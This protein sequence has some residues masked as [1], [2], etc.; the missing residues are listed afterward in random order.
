M[1][2]LERFFRQIVLNLAA[3]DPARLHRPLPLTDIRESIVPYRANRRALQLES[4]EDYELVV[5]RLC[6][7]E[8]GLARTE[9]DEVRAE[10]V[11]EVGGPNPD[12]T[13]VKRHGEALVSL[14]P[15]SLAQALD[16]KPK[17]AYA[18]WEEQVSEAQQAQRPVVTPTT[19][20]S[21]QPG[22]TAPTPAPAEEQALRCTHCGAG[23]PVGRLVNFCPKCGQ[24]QLRCPKCKAQLEAGWRHCVGCGHPLGKG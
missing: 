15:K 4:N 23:L 17:L 24:S 5:M 12:L 22:K 3:T 2:D 9:P 8:G 20:P 16:P 18:P 14:E 11:R 21:R 13:I 6:A 7:G 1:N 19:K 10:F